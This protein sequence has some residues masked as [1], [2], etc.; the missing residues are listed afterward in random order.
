MDGENDDGEDDIWV[1][2]LGDQSRGSS[3]EFIRELEEDLNLTQEEVEDQKAWDE[4]LS[5]MSDEEVKELMI[6]LEEDMRNEDLE[7]IEYQSQT[8]QTRLR[9]EL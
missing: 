3:D 7:E 1:E 2:Y 6:Q 8:N 4:R 5:K 9:D